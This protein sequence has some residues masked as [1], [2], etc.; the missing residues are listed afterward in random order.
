M[1]T[2]IVQHGVQDYGAWRTVYE[3]VEDLRLQYGCNAKRVWQSPADANQVLVLHDFP[4]ADQ[5]QAFADS[6][7]LKSAMQRAGVA[8]PPSVAIWEDTNG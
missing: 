7:E 6:A 5:A 1:A 4:T 3:E 2:L 8:G